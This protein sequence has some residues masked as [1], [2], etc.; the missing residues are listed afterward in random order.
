MTVAE[1]RARKGGG[2]GGGAWPAATDLPAA[3]HVLNDG[4]VN[5]TLLA[6]SGPGV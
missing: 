2:C 3:V 4:D 6:N 5:M 1:G